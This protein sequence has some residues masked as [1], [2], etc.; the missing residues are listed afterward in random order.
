MTKIK[1]KKL[2]P[3]A[4]TPHY[5]HDG[6]AG[7][8]VYSTINFSLKPNHRAAIPTGLSFELPKGF[9][10]QIRPKSGIALKAGVTM[11]NA[12]GTLDSGYR[13]ELKV[14]MINHS[15]ED[16]QIKKGEKIAQIVFAR[17]EEA[18]LEETEEISETARGSGGF[19]STGL[20]KN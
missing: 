9:E 8:D 17:Y 12:P 13:G 2:N 1:I 15:S 6:D 16:Y 4:I 19:G 10:I 18:E 5:A 7:M 3:N 14:I 11:I 20:G